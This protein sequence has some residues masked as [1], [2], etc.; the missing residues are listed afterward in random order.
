[1]YLSAH[2]SLLPSQQA[3]KA[4]ISFCSHF[5]SG[6]PLIPGCLRQSQ[7]KPGTRA[8]SRYGLMEG[9]IYPSRLE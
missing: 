2:S 4:H 8:G 7:A 9:C 5:L 3:S 1:M 6:I